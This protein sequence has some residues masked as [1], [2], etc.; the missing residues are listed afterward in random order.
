MKLL[1]IHYDMHSEIDSDFFEIETESKEEIMSSLNN[2]MVDK[3]YTIEIYKNAN[4]L[5]LIY[6]Q[7]EGI[8]VYLYKNRQ[9]HSEVFLECPLEKVSEVVSA[10][11]ENDG[12]RRIIEKIEAEKVRKKTI[13][14][15]KFDKWKKG[16]AVQLEQDQKSNKKRNLIAVLISI[17]ILGLIYLIWTDELRF[18]WRRT[19]TVEAVVTKAKFYKEGGRFYY[20]RVYYEFEF[21]GKE[22][23]GV[24]KGNKY[25]GQHEKGDTILVKIAVADPS[26]SKRI[27]RK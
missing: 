23:S 24:F 21:D 26:A 11:V 6:F 7:R 5:L 10:F 19:Q 16:Y 20:Q 22:Y 3:T 27:G 4:E 8:N 1:I 13:E 17:L 2:L 9:E 14:K 15:E 25:T 18:I 12:T